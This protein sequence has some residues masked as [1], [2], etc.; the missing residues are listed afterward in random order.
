M[1]HHNKNNVGNRPASGKSAAGQNY[2]P[3]SQLKLLRRIRVPSVLLKGFLFQ[4]QEELLELVDPLSHP[5]AGRD[6]FLLG[7]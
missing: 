3:W 4:E 7:V 5:G 2:G 1:Y 6:S